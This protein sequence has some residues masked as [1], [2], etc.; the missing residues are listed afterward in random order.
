MMLTLCIR[1]LTE[2]KSNRVYITPLSFGVRCLSTEFIMGQNEVF[3]FEQ[4]DHI[5]YHDDE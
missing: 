4:I 5:K 2:T 3:N 1:R